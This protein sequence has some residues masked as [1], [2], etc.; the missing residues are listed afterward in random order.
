MKSLLL[1]VVL[2][3]FS[4]IFYQCVNKSSNSAKVSN[5][6]D[7]LSKKNQELKDKFSKDQ[8]ELEKKYD[9]LMSKKDSVQDKKDV[10]QI[11]DDNIY[12]NKTNNN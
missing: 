12:R 3:I 9:S 4:G 5:I 11:I 7:S 6:E 2:I 1:I 8:K 10:S